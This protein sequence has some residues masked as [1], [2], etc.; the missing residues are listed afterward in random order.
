MVEFSTIMFNSGQIDAL[1]LAGG[2]NTRIPVPKGFLVIN[3]QRILDRNIHLF[4]GIF[5]RILISTNSPELYFSA[6]ALMVGD[7]IPQK[8][9]MTGIYSA[10]MLPDVQAVFVTA[11]DMPFINVILVEEIL[12][13]WDGRK[14]AVIPVYRNRPEPLFGIYA[15]RIACV[16]EDSIR[17]GEKSLRAFLGKIDVRYVEEEEVRRMDPEGKSFVNINTLEDYQKETGGKACLD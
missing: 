15:K 13:R 4:K 6:G 16:M 14:D 7:I 2:E 17:K 9:P 1:I 5:K 11:C 8:G 3:N 12:T 10:L